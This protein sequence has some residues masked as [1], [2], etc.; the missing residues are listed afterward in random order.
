MRA[1]TLLT[2]IILTL[3]DLQSQNIIT[4]EECYKL[5]EQNYPLIQQ[6][7]LI[8]EA[9]HYTI[10]NASKRALPSLVIQGLQSY[11]SDVTQVPFNSPEI[12]IEPQSKHQYKIFSEVSV[13][14][15]D[16]GTVR[17]EKQRAKD[18]AQINDDQ[19]QVE[20]YK[21]RERINDLY[22]GIIIQD[23]QLQLNELLQDDIQRGIAR[24]NAVVEQGSALRSS[25]DVLQ[26]E[27]LKAQQQQVDILASR[28]AYIEMLGLLTG[29]ALSAETSFV[30]PEPA[31]AADEI[32]RP[33]LRVFAQ[34]KKA[35]DVYDKMIT[36]RQLPKLSVFFQGGYGRPALNMLDNDAEPYY[37]TG[38]RLNWTITNFYT[39]KKERA[40]LEIQRRTIDV[41]AE[42]FQL[43]T[44]ILL[45]QQQGEIDR[46]QKALRTDDEIINIRERIKNTAEAQL[47][48]GVIQ[49]DDYLD[50]VTAED[51]SRQNKA[52]HEAMLVYAQYKMNTLSGNGL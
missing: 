22:F 51:Q 40:L 34:Q 52:I 24:V 46:L 23:K 5:A 47:A 14:I 41:Q 27:L 9:K 12:H 18:E 17:H 19:L 37:Y 49:A 28:R 10:S 26:A 39:A 29:R 38:V 33:E 1:I 16:G 8:S 35:F 2:L 43:N 36:A 25:A 44:Q 20:L 30:I 45:R 32:T 13:P 42:T 7:D 31:P 21:L 6:R 4:L 50:E 15:F 48:N 11:Q 3:T